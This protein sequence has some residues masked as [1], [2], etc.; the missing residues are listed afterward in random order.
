MAVTN[1]IVFRRDINSLLTRN[2]IVHGVNRQIIK[3]ICP[4]IIKKPLIR[5]I[6]TI[7]VIHMEIRTGITT[8]ALIE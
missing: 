6:I 1:T 5:R 8:P 2:I 7:A 3:K 4:E